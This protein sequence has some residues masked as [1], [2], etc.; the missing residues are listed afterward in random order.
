L[1]LLVASGRYSMFEVVDLYK[2]FVATVFPPSRLRRACYLA[3]SALELVGVH[4]ASPLY[5]AGPLEKL[6][7]QYLSD[8]A[9]RWLQM[10]EARTR[11]AVT[12][13]DAESE[14]A[15]LLTSYNGGASVKMWQ[16]ARA[17]SAAQTYFEPFACAVGLDT[18]ALT[19]GGGGENNPSRTAL[20]E[21][22]AAGFPDP[23][24]ISIG[25]GRS[26]R[27]ESIE[28]LRRLGLIGWAPRMLRFTMGASADWA[29]HLCARTLPAGRYFRFQ[30]DIPGGVSVAMDDA[31]PRNVAAMTTWASGFVRERSRE[32]DALAVVLAGA[33]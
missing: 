19:D 1:G 23:L 3:Q 9:G 26:R 7:Q 8:G 16:A 13:W 12:T 5:A 27:V 21:A 22:V 14:S 25:T 29:D 20:A 15:Y 33:S 4:A 24:L 32:L 10:G 17:T 30:S 31:H 2:D 28:E 18:M 6:L 11:V